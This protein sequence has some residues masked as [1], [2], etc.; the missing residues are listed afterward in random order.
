M[1]EAP[2]TVALL[3][4][5]PARRGEVRRLA[6]LIDRLASRGVTAR[7]VTPGDGPAL[8]EHGVDPLEE[9]WLA[10]PWLAR[11]AARRLPMADPDFRPELVHALHDEAAEAAAALARRRDLPLIRTVEDDPGL[12]AHPRIEPRGLAAL[13]S[14]DD[15]LAALLAARDQGFGRIV[16]VIPPGFDPPDDPGPVEDSPPVDRVPVIGAMGR[17]GPGSGFET[18]LDA[19]HRVVETGR[20]VEFLVA[21]L[22]PGE[23]RVR[24]RADRLGIADRLTFAGPSTLEEGFWR[25]VDVYDQPAAVPTCGRSLMAAMAAGKPCVASDLDGPRQLLRLGERG[26]LVPPGDPAALARAMLSLLDQP[27]LAR[28]LADRAR[29]WASS[30]FD[31]DREADALASLYGA[32]ARPASPPA[33][34]RRS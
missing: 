32:V 22:G 21:G 26:L 3:S 18:F 6:R 15:R 29:A 8:R 28:S 5:P 34:T 16:R 7:L 25:V 2:I 27:L 4:G 30:Q 19:I 31:P 33:A 17:L 13:V 23:S 12:D 9:P 20:D 24:R 1:A 14:C 10:R 11:V